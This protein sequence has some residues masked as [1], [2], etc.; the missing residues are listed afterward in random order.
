VLPAASTRALIVALSSLR[1]GVRIPLSGH[2]LLVA[3]FL[4]RRL[5]LRNVPPRQSRL[6][7]W[8]AATILKFRMVQGNLLGAPASRRLLLKCG[9]AGR[10]R[11][12]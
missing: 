5:W 3:W 12:Q 6:E 7:V 9:P 8:I 2:A 4:F 11:S 10:Q 1:L